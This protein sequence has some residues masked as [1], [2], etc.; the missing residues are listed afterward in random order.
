MKTYLRLSVT[1]ALM[2][3]ML[4]GCGNNKSKDK[5]LGG[6]LSGGDGSS[7]TTILSPVSSTQNDQAASAAQTAALAA[8][9]ASSGM[10]SMGAPQARAVMNAS[11]VG[12]PTNPFGNV[13][14]EGYYNM[15]RSNL[16]PEQGGSGTFRLRF[17]DNSDNTVDLFNWTGFSQ[18]PPTFP[19]I[20]Y[21]SVKV[22]GTDPEG[23]TF[24]ATMRQDMGVQ[25]GTMSDMTNFM[26]GNMI[27]TGTIN[28]SGPMGTFTFTSELTI[29]NATGL[30]VSGTESGSGTLPDGTQVTISI[31]WANGVGDGTVTVNG[32]TV[33]IHINA[34]G[35]G[36][37]RDNGGTHAIN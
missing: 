29:S 7:G 16:G 12:M 5:L 32:E 22:S 34:D 19:I 4:S 27:M 37:Y 2:V 18:F 10:G 1:A 8:S 24:S 20:R 33:I 3:G 14:S 35:S 25:T 15:T 26:T 30:V 13:D 11:R 17:S 28:V 9:L 36:T 21:V 23:N 31:V 6:N